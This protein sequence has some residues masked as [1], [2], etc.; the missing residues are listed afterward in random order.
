[1]TCTL[2]SEHLRCVNVSPTDAGMDGPGL[3]AWVLALVGRR[4][5]ITV[6]HPS[7]VWG[8]KELTDSRN[9]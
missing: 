7:H 4:P 1:M 9:T 3:D 5:L 8:N 2:L 6:C